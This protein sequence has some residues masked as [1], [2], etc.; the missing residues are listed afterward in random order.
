VKRRFA[1]GLACALVA[2]AALAQDGVSV[3]GDVKQALTLSA[4]DLRA[5]ETKAQ[6][7]LRERRDAGSVQR[8]TTLRGVSLAAVI[9][10]AGLAERERLDWRKTVVIAIARDGYRA[11]FSWPELVNTD[12]G[13]LVMVAYERD[14]RALAD[15]EGPLALVAPADQ[16][17][18]PRRVKWLQRIDVRILRD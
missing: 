2:G 3:S 17:P 7:E 1:L 14:G 11:A 9:E 6:R 13:A 8:D 10:R 16:R 5:F 18:G 12:G 4:N 15:D